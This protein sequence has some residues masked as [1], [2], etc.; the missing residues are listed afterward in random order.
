[1]LGQPKTAGAIAREP[2]RARQFLWR[3][4]I[5][6]MCGFLACAASSGLAEEE[7][8]PEQADVDR[9][10]RLEEEPSGVVFEIRE[11]DEEALSWVAARMRQ[12]I[13]QLRARYPDLDIAVLSHGDE[14]FSLRTE[15]RANYPRLHDLVQHLV[16]EEGVNFHVCGIFAASNGMTP[17]DFP[18]FVDVS[19]SGPEQLQDYLNLGY[20][21]VTLE[22]TW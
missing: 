21:M 8:L 22:L 12:Y 16:E 11:Y 1:M 19:P 15:A 18:N 6:L 4:V 3:L 7:P 20:R 14:M 5:S 2:F 10:L 17:E 9:I 13:S